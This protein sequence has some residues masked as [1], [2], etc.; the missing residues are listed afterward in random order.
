MKAVVQRVKRASVS[1]E[2]KTV[3]SIG[4]GLLILLGVCREDDDEASALLARKLANMRIFSDPNDKMN[5]SLLNV[6]GE[7]LVISNFT[8]C[9][10]LRKGT[11]PS[12]DPAMPPLEADR[13]YERFCCCLGELGVKRV[14]RGVFGA[15]MSVELVNDGPVT[16]SV[17]SDIWNRPRNSK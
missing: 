3:G 11:R 5:L 7:A 6:G 4:E 2:G 16:V 15:D 10:D 14:E 17:D 9:A 12:F 8:L 13:L 1:V